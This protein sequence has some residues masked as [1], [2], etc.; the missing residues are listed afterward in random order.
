MG[1]DRAGDVAATPPP[2]PPDV[3]GRLR[4]ALEGGRIALHYQ[5]LVELPS[6]RPVAVEALARWHDDELGVVPP[7]V[8]IPVAEQ[9]GLIFELGRQVL[10]EACR[11]MASWDPSAAQLTININVSPLQLEDERFVGLVAEALG[12]SGLDPARLCLEITEMTAVENLRLTG[13]R[14]E[15]LRALGV[16]I[17]LDDFGTGYSSLTVLRQLPVDVVKMDRAFVRN[18][19]SDARDAVLARLIIDAAH[20]MGM[21]VCAE[22]VERDDQARQLVG[23]GCDRAQGW[24]FAAALPPDAERLAAVR[25]GDP[26]VTAPIATDDPGLPLLGTDELVL[27]T[28]ADGVLT[29]VSAAAVRLL[30]VAPADLVGTAV[31][32]HLTQPDVAPGGPQ[33]LSEG[34]HRHAVVRTVD[35]VARWLDVTTRTVRDGDGH[36]R[37]VVSVARDVTAVVRAERELAESERRFRRAFDEAPIGMA[38]TTLEGAFLRVNAAFA[39]M[40]GMAADDVLGTTVEAL[41]VEED[42]AADAANLAEARRG[43]TA[44]HEV[45]KRYRHV[46]GHAVAARVRAAVVPGADGDEPYILAHVLPGEGGPDPRPDSPADDVAA[47]DFPG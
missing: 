5:P 29:F 19:T 46:D 9:A 28:R 44:L 1:A 41:T 34:Q 3:E 45:A 11:R 18:L 6:G 38:I 36:P 25:A 16:R 39:A 37:E 17:A 2:G 7:D 40:L 12:A 10:V 13:R 20:A 32:E 23:L 24:L 31:S 8:F 21:R 27:V 14:L 35:G 26:L 30:G 22:G 43:D 33:V 42:R 47:E 4:A 15:A